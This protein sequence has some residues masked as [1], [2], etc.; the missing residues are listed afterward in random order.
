MILGLGNLLFGDANRSFLLP[1]V[2]KGKNI[3]LAHISPFPCRHVGDDPVTHGS[4]SIKTS[5][6]I[7]RSARSGGDCRHN[8]F[9]SI[10][11]F[12][13]LRDSN[14]CPEKTEYQERTQ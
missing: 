5:F 6:D 7:D 4:Y 2:E 8:A 3:T 9:G 10:R 14:R 13:R 11:A 1:S 12:I